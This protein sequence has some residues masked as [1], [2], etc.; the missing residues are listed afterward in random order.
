M[1]V[2]V[3]VVFCCAVWCLHSHR[4]PNLQ[5]FFFVFQKWILLIFLNTFLIGLYD[6]ILFFLIYNNKITYYT[7]NKSNFWCYKNYKCVQ[8][9][10][11]HKRVGKKKQVKVIVTGYKI[12]HEDNVGSSL[13]IYRYFVYFL[14]IYY[15]F[16]KWFVNFLA[17]CMCVCDLNAV[18]IANNVNPYTVA[19]IQGLFDRQTNFI[20]YDRKVIER[21][22][23]LKSIYA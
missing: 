16:K 9:T 22:R 14:Y 6:G 23:K 3:C 12:Y 4:I 19:I 21:R 20:F 13:C 8:V 2:C 17:N 7:H 11:P 10:A 15:Y 1:L 18:N 5:Q